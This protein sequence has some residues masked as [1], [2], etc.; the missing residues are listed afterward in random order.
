[1][2]G[3]MSTARSRDLAKI[4]AVRLGFAH[5]RRPGRTEVTRDAIYQLALAI[6]D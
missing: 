4:R 6:G 3:P 2:P 1:M 5:G